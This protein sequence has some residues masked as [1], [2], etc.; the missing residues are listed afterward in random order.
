MSRG[1]WK[2][3][4]RD[5]GIQIYT[6]DPVGIT[7]NV[8]AVAQDGR[9]GYGCSESE[10]VANLADWRPMREFPPDDVTHLRITPSEAAKLVRSAHL[11][12]LNEAEMEAVVALLEL[13]ALFPV[14]FWKAVA[15]TERFGEQRAD[16]LALVAEELYSVRRKIAVLK[17]LGVSDE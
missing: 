17:N 2:L 9:V 14:E 7:S 1:P 16:V 8:C 11:M 10:A 6:K 4:I 15:E 13:M 12:V 3:K 5:D